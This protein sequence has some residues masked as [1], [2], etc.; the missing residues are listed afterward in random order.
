[1]SEQNKQTLPQ[2]VLISGI[3][4]GSRTTQSGDYTNNDI[5]ISVQI[6]DGYGGFNEQV[7]NVSVFGSR[8]DEL[9]NRANELKGKHV[10]I[11]VL[12]RAMKSERTGNAYLNQSIHTES[13]LIS[14][15]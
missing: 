4:K 11:S 1:M 7:E 9:M 13:Q 2:G 10:V 6:P 3:C 15:G 5:G 12:R 14:L 8:K